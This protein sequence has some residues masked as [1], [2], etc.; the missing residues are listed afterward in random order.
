M[1]P[2]EVG[3]TAAIVLAGGAGRR[4]GSDKTRAILGGHT[5]LERTLTAAAHVVDEVV[6][7]GPWAPSGHQHVR[8]PEPGGGP[9][10]ALAFGLRQVDADRVLVL[11]ADHPQLR[12]PLLRALL[13]HFGDHD[14]VVPLANGEPQPLVAW[15]QSSVAVTA[16]RLLAGGERRLRSLL[17]AIDVRWVDRPGWCDHDHDGRSFLDVDEPGQLAALQRSAP[18]RQEVDGIADVDTERRWTEH[19][20]G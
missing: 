4:F 20:E 18:E 16:D 8:E 10:A 14:A 7:I 6:V 2:P 17:D 12:P 1:A 19:H 13:D 11:A 9:L 5:L 3:S 15:Y